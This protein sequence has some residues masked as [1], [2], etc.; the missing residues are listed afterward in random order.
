MTSA[1]P[2]AILDFYGN[3]T[4]T[5]HVVTTKLLFATHHQVAGNVTC[6]EEKKREIYRVTIVLHMRLDLRLHIVRKKKQTVKLTC[7]TR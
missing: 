1:S 4:V 2:H 6:V 7:A 3:L 5:S